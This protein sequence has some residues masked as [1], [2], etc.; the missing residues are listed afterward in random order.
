MKRVLSDA[1]Q[2]IKV[3]EKVADVLGNLKSAP[4]N[5]ALIE[6]L[7]IASAAFQKQ[8]GLALA[9]T[10][11]GAE[12]LLAAVTEGKASARLLQDRAVKD[13]VLAAKPVDAAERLQTLTRNL[14]PPSEERQKM[15][16]QRRAAFRS[17]EPAAAQ[18][19][20]LFKQHCSICHTID[21]QGSQIGPQLDGIGARGLDRLLE[22][23]VD[24]SRNVDKAF[25]TSLFI[26][27]DGE[28]QS[29]LF[30]R[31][32]GE[33]IV[34]AESTGK[35]ISVP[36]STVKE[37]RES[38]MSLMPDNIAEVL[39]ADDFNHLLAYLLSKGPTTGA[40]AR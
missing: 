3:R 40:G 38:E 12:A 39:S 14:A 19:S 23:I 32:E 22:D 9:G 37:R 1:D 17:S 35:E 5:A 11:E 15:I 36:K 26:L 29:G 18:G 25:R 31:E 30:R 10:P 4:A 8:I 27:N 6:T 7:P 16:D 24:P 2:P 28:V 33:T 21:G 20:A 13:R 34:L